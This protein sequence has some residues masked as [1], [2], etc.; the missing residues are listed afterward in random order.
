MNASQGRCTLKFGF[1]ESVYCHFYFIE[2]LFVDFHASALGIENSVVALGE[3][4]VFFQQM[5]FGAVTLEFLVYELNVIG[6][7]GEDEVGFFEHADSEQC[8]AVRPYVDFFIHK[9]L[10]GL[11][12]GEKLV[13]CH[14]AAGLDVDVI[15]AALA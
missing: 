13:G 6:C 7:H 14:H 15:D 11:G 2:S 12:C 9:Q 5:Y 3:A 8:A 1:Y 4:S 10:N